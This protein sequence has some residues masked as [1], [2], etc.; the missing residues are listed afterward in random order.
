M[1]RIS[2]VIMTL[3]LLVLHSGPAESAPKAAMGVTLTYA[4]EPA[5]VE[6][7]T[8]AGRIVFVDVYDGGNMSRSPTGQ[9]ILLTTHFHNDHYSKTLA[10][11]FPGRQLLAETGKIEL[12]DV[13]ITGIAAAHDSNDPILDK[14]GTDY[15]YIIETGGLRIVHFGDLGQDALTAEQMAAIGKVDVAISQL[16]N[17]MSDMDAGNLKGFNLMEQVRP[18]LFIPTHSDNDT[19]KIAV[20]RWKGFYSTSRTIAISSATLPPE[21]SVLILGSMSLPYGKVLKLELWQ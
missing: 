3:L 7:V 10:D 5:D 15:I 1:N 9:D 21:R 20:G 18:R 8:P 11:A 12:P 19:I 13:T 2:S 17:S 14:G 4:A 6:I 16:S